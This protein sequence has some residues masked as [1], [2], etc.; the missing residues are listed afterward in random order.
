[1]FDKRYSGI[2]TTA[3][4]LIY[5]WVKSNRWEI[6]RRNL[7]R[8]TYVKGGKRTKGIFSKFTNSLVI[9]IW[10]RP[11]YIDNRIEFGHWEMDLIIG[12]REHGY[13]NL[14]TFQERK[15]RMV[16]I[17]KIKTKDPM[18]LNST[19]YKLIKSNN[20]KVKSI[21]IDNGMEFSKIGLLAN[22]VKCYIYFCEPYAS[23][24]RGSNEHVNGIIRRFWRKGTDFSQLSNSDIQDA[25]NKINT[26]P[27]EMFNWKSSMQIF[28]E[29]NK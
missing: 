28:N 13:E 9:P 10:A 12:K 5:N 25:Q 22:W 26:M 27:R 2:K 23:Y 11:K 8:K 15:T 20:L 18:K 1:M 6:K 4:K 21:T 19:V 7:L 24:Q 14:I 17:E 29:I 16:F 3:Y